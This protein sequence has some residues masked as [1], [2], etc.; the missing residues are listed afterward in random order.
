MCA[1][2]AV[3]RKWRYPA[4]SAGNL[5]VVKMESA[6]DGRQR[7]NWPRYPQHRDDF[8]PPRRRACPS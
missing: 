8:A 1:E 2:K 6:S 5:S 4:E 7:A 3:R